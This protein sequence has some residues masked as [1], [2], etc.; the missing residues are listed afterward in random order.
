MYNIDDLNVKL[1]S[2]LKEIAEGMGIKNARKLGKQELVYKILDEQAVAGAPAVAQ[3]QA[4]KE[5]KEAK[6]G[7]EGDS[8]RRMRPR[9]REN[10]APEGATSRIERQHN[11]EPVKDTNS[12]DLLQNLDVDLESSMPR[13]E[14]AEPSSPGF[15]PP[16]MD[17]GREQEQEPPRPTA[18]PP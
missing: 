17:E 9:R 12:D 14:E 5:P 8:E 18:P 11:A 2:E 10:V 15:E 4:K 6:E 7:K 3:P 13:F 16:R 1:L